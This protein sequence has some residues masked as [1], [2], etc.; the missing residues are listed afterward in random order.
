[1]EV[2]EQE[3]KEQQDGGFR[4]EEAPG[5]NQSEDGPKIDKQ[6]SAKEDFLKKLDLRQ[7]G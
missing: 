2:Q 3:D 5:R 7:V 6:S 4:D 1:M